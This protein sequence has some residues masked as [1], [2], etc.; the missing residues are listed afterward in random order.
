MVTINPVA[1]VKVLCGPAPAKLLQNG[2][3]S[4]LVK[5]Q[6]EANV[7]A[8]LQVDSPNAQLPI[9]RFEWYPKDLKEK[10]ITAGQVAIR[11]LELQL[12][13][14]RPLLPNLS[15]LL[16]EY[17]VVQ[18][19][20]KA[21]YT[22]SLNAFFSWVE[23]ARQQGN[24]LVGFDALSVEAFISESRRQGQSPFTINVRLSAIKA[25]AGWVLAH[26]QKFPLPEENRQ[27]LS[28]IARVGTLATE[29]MY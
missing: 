4:F 2:W 11:F 8:E 16:L 21:T 15:G 6:N 26:P 10:S 28:A 17:A 12:Y 13:K 9:Q 19:Y 7:T 23:D 14:N 3:K 18:I 29:K 25:L 5:V 24:E 1:R 20:S 22:K 27:G